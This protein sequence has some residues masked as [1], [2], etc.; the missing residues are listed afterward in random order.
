MNFE[1][2]AD[3]TNTTTEK[4]RNPNNNGRTLGTAMVDDEKERER[5][6]DRGRETEASTLQNALKIEANYVLFIAIPTWLPPQAHLLVGPLLSH[7]TLKNCH[8]TAT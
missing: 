1:E 7:L 3:P 4:A 8:V 2:E 6:R 5:Q